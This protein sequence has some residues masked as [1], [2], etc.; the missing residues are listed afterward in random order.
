M[1]V[2]TA[3]PERTLANEGTHVAVCTQIIDHG[4]KEGENGKYRAFNFGF[5]LV[6]EDPDSEGNPVMV[7]RQFAGK[8]NPDE[9]ISITPRSKL[10]QAIAAWL[11][12]P[13]D[14]DSEFTLESLAGKACQVTI[15]HKEVEDKTYAN[16]TSVIGLSKGV[17]AKRP[18][19]D[20]KVLFL[21]KDEFDQDVFD[22]L[23]DF[24]QEAIEEAPEYRAM[25]AKKS[26][27]PP[28]KKGKKEKAPF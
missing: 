18:T 5:E 9:S 1:K 24:V 22:S 11:G 19:S 12:K 16:I 23:P 14:K 4:T 3:G 20:I 7:F 25:F 8:I 17:K 27:Q 6:E 28:V 10:G 15:V 13:L 26:K 21:D 2:S